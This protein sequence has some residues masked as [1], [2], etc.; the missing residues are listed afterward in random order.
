M[1][2]TYDSSRLIG[3]VG[4]DLPV[5]IGFNEKTIHINVGEPKELN[6]EKNIQTIRVE[7]DLLQAPLYVG[8]YEVSQKLYK[9]VMGKNPSYFRGDNLPV[10]Q[11]S[12]ID[13]II[14]CNKLSKNNGYTPC[15]SFKGE[16]NTDRWQIK[17]LDD[18]RFLSC[19]FKA[20]GYRLP[21]SAEDATLARALFIFIGKVITNENYGQG[22]RKDSGGK[23]ANIDDG[24]ITP[25]GLYN[26]Q[27]NV[28]EW[29]WEMKPYGISWR[30]N[31]HDIFSF[32]DYPTAE[33]QLDDIKA[34]TDYTGFRVVR[35]DTSK[36]SA[37]AFSNVQS[38][39]L[40]NYTAE[41][42]VKSNSAN[43]AKSFKGFSSLSFCVGYSIQDAIDGGHK[44]EL[45]KKLLKTKD[46]VEMHTGVTYKMDGSKI[47]VYIPRTWLTQYVSDIAGYTTKHDSV[48]MRFT[49]SNISKVTVNGVQQTSG[50]TCFKFKADG[51]ADMVVTDTAGGTS[52]YTLVLAEPAIVLYYGA[53]DPDENELGTVTLITRN[54]GELTKDDILFEKNAAGASIRAFEQI[55]LVGGNPMNAFS[56]YIIT[57][58]DYKTTGDI[59]I[60]VK[61]KDKPVVYASPWYV[62]EDKIAGEEVSFGGT[63]MYSKEDF[64][65]GASRVSITKDNINK[66]PDKVFKGVDD[67]RLVLPDGTTVTKEAQ[68]YKT[69]YMFYVVDD[70]DLTKCKFDIKYSAVAVKKIEMST[71]ELYQ[72]GLDE[73]LKKD[74]NVVDPKKTT[75]NFSGSGAQ[76]VYLYFVDYNNN[77]LT[78]TLTVRKRSRATQ[79]FYD[80][81]N[82]TPSTFTGF[83]NITAQAPGRSSYA[84]SPDFSLTTPAYALGDPAVILPGKGNNV[85]I[86][87]NG[88]DPTNY[89]LNL[90]GADGTYKAVYYSA[91]YIDDGDVENYLKT[92]PQY[93]SGITPLPA[94]FYEFYLF[95]VDNNGKIFRYDI[96]YPK[97]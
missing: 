41:S 36:L 10:E 6:T 18:L 49:G 48:M 8:R 51:T 90:I 3:W 30:L 11:V 94:N 60:K 32:N 97:Y 74:K 67:I 66:S 4:K 69:S 2:E 15:Y 76:S 68:E 19:N 22:R 40:P 64:L 12:W 91:D 16:T 81:Q 59:I 65:K 31:Q 38:T 37:N 86:R 50:K 82:A 73:I 70:L 72:D 5:R 71:T 17:T 63:L 7:S 35:T 58:G 52:R 53:T 57:F 54:Y 61:E 87:L 13:A 20:N 42:E 96:M 25:S 45:H 80:K 95:V 14:F 55:E 47:S 29:T 62:S 24:D 92:A 78:H 9:D 34:Y 89:K 46:M 43:I 88:K 77:I 1:T 26:I 56:S 83:T 27:G 33:K 79:N 28:A 39:V 84:Y 21:T 93:I 75:F 85:R 44:L 23:T